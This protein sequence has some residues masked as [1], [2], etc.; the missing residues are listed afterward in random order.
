M[1]REISK[2]QASRLINCGMVILVTAAYKDK[3]TITPCAWHLPLSKSPSSLGIAL[4]RSHFS[5][6]LIRKSEEFIINIPD[7]ALLDKLVACG[8]CSGRDVDKFKEA[9]LT[10]QKGG[11]LVKTPRISECIGHLECSLIDIKEVGDHFLF[12][13]EI[14]QA[15]AEEDYFRGGIWDTGKV[16]LIFHLGSK[17]F[18]KSS[19]YIEFNRE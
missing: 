14:I 5:S 1:K 11:S 9:K 15:Q 8:K 6:E 12:L 19:E 10:P 7:W 16:N 18:F 17:F 3:T 4:A 13:G 2:S